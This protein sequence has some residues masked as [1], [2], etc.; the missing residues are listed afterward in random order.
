MLNLMEGSPLN[1][2]GAARRLQDPLSIRNIPQVY[3]AF[4]AAL[5]HAREAVEVEIN[6]AADSPGVVVAR[7]EIA[8]HGGYLTPHLMIALGA[9][10]Q[11]TAQMAATQAR[12]R[13]KCCRGGSQTCQAA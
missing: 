12:G 7:G 5:A 9:L 13:A 2:P 6:A 8:S 3:G 1:K 10:G 4:A 11:A